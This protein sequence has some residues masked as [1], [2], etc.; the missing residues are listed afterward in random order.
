MATQAP[1]AVNIIDRE[2][3]YEPHLEFGYLG[4][5]AG[6]INPFRFVDVDSSGNF[7]QATAASGLCIGA[8]MKEVAKVSGERM[9]VNQGKIVVEASDVIAAGKPIAVGD[10]AR[11]IQFVDSATS[12]TAI[13]TTSAG[14]AFTNQPSN[15]SVEVLSASAADT[16]QVVTLIGTTT[17][18]DTVVVQTVALNGT[19]AVASAKVDWGQI[20]AVKLSASCAGT[21]T[22]RKTT[23][24]GTIT[25]LTTGVLS[26]G[27]ET[28]TTADQQAFNQ[29]PTAVAS[30]SS[31][32]QIGIQ[33]TD[34]TGA[35]I[36]NSKALNGTTAVTF[37]SAF[38]RVT[39]V[40]TGDLES[41]RTAVV[42]VGAALSE[43]LRVGK[44]LTAATAAGDRIA[45]FCWP[46]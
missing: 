3:T 4:K 17:A 43:T 26:K 34:A 19:T 31:T 10:I 13:K 35:V 11:A 25:T 7:V 20:L 44:A 22:I 46:T 12:G 14:I 41:S 39:E 28:V 40:Y 42:A 32:K 18:T 29:K 5:A 9:H 24:P 6:T 2:A 23:G 1:N 38:K 15:D 21:V 33:G 45:A 37:V 16:T 36:Y 27:V 30:G 8:F